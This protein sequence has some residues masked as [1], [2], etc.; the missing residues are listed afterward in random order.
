MRTVRG[1]FDQWFLDYSAAARGV[2]IKDGA[3]AQKKG[4]PPAHFLGAGCCA[5]DSVSWHYV[6]ADVARWLH[7]IDF[8]PQRT[9]GAPAAADGK[10]AGKAVS[11]PASLGELVERW[12]RHTGGYA[13]R[14]K[15]GSE[16]AKALW[17]LLVLK[18]SVPG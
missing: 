6:E 10:A 13:R 15:P 9:A 5:A 2:K 11:A 8:S 16:A 3:W 18:F 14:P 17:E 7:A 12:P 1:K 4:D